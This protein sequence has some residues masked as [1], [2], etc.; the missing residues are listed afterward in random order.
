MCF[1]R[2]KD[3]EKGTTKIETIYGMKCPYCG[4]VLA[5]YTASGGYLRAYC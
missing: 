4:E 2:R 3:F 1:L 5:A